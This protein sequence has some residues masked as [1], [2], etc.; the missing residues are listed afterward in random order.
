MS[1]FNFGKVLI[2]KGMIFLIITFLFTYSL[3]AR[4][5]SAFY[6]K[7]CGLGYTTASVTLAQRGTLTGVLQPAGMNLTGI[8]SSA[9]IERAF[10]YA[11]SSGNGVPVTLNITNPALSSFSIPLNITGSDTDKCWGFSGTYLYKADITSVICGNGSYVISG[12]P[13]ILT[14]PNNDMDGAS[15][16]VVYRDTTISTWNGELL[17]IEGPEIRKN[18]PGAYAQFFS[19]LSLPCNSS[20]SRQGIILSDVETYPF[21]TVFPGSTV[22]STPGMWT[23]IDTTRISYV[24][25]G[26]LHFHFGTTMSSTECYSAA[27]KWAYSRSTCCLNCNNLPVLLTFTDSLPADCFGNATGTATTY[28]SLGIPPYSYSWSTNPVQTT[29]SATGLSAGSYTI[30]VTDA[31]GCNYKVTDSVLIT[32]PTGLGILNPQ[33]VIPTCYGSTNGSII[34]S[35]LGGTPPYSYLW[36]TGATTNFISGI[37]AGAYSVSITDANGCVIQPLISLTEPPVLQSNLI[38]ASA[39][40]NGSCNGFAYANPFGGSAPYSFLWQNGS[41]TFTSS[42]LCAGTYS[43]LVTDAAGCVDTANFQVSQPATPLSLSSNATNVSCYMYSNGTALVLPSGGDPPYSYV[44]MPGSLSTASP[45]GLG[46]GQ[47]TVAVTD[48]NGCMVKDTVQVMS[49]FPLV[50]SAIQDTNICMGDSVLFIANATG[51]NPGYSYTW[52]PQGSNGNAFWASPSSQTT[53]TLSVTDVNNCP[54]N[55]VSFTVTPYP[56]PQ[57]I[58]TLSS[59]DSII[60]LGEELCI[61][62]NSLNTQSTSYILTNLTQ[63][64]VSSWCFFAQDTGIACFDFTLLNT[65]GCRVDT[66]LCLRVFGTYYPNIFTPNGDGI[67]DVLLFPNSGMSEMKCDIYNRWGNL[68]VHLQGDKMQWEGFT[69]SGIPA[70]EGVYYYLLTGEYADGQSTTYSGYFHLVR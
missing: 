68:V 41:T 16:I 65:I 10:F 25:P 28:P 66:T 48:S 30:V 38:V 19:G 29:Q 6:I 26:P 31:S 20:Y 35:P 34:V 8:P 43:V 13:T 40:C 17:L 52:M 5:D 4:S 56:P 15:I 70:S 7:K 46:A 44:W 2:S 23:L 18:V 9:I 54:S 32:S 42:G 1:A 69:A 22:N 53:Y 14:D 3:S 67:N 60:H 51:G 61:D 12:L 33:L 45:T 47:Y 62:Q 55:P 59:P 50:L 27:V 39:T 64:P 11:Q 63:S 24:Q 58:L 57:P 21:Q 37:P 36:S 49:P